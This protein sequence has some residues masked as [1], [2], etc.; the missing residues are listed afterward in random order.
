MGS[1]IVFKLDTE[2]QRLTRLCNLPDIILAHQVIFLP[3]TP[4]AQKGTVY[5]FG[6]LR[7]AQQ[8]QEQNFKYDVAKDEWTS[9]MSWMPGYYEI[10]FN[11]LPLLENRFILVIK[12]SKLVLFDT[13]TDK[14]IKLQ[15][16]GNADLIEVQIAAFTLPIG[17][18][19]NMKKEGEQDDDSMK[20]VH[21]DSDSE[22]DAEGWEDVPA[23]DESFEAEMEE[24]FSQCPVPADED[25][26]NDVDSEMVKF[27][28]D[29][30]LEK[31]PQN[32]AAKEL[33]ESPLNI[34]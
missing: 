18:L 27:D 19:P 7:T 4:K 8:Y 1:D 10:S 16:H 34:L 31:S 26:S 24:E 29:D 32:S 2:T 15:Q 28:Q 5:A 3:A 9:V 20:S 13:E 17:V 22:S 11:L 25:Y 33:D 6:G 23:E 14:F 12:R 21:S 30:N